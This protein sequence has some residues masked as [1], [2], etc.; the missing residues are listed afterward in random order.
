MVGVRVAAGRTDGPRRAD[1]PARTEDLAEFLLALQGIDATDGPPPESSNGFRGCDL[2]DERDSP[3]VR[4]HMAEK[5]DAARRHPRHGTDPR[6]VG[7]TL[8]P[9][10]SGH[11]SR[12]GCTA[13]RPRRTCWPA[14][15]R[16]SA[17]IDFGTLAVGDPAVDMI[18]AWS[19]LDAGQPK[20]VPRQ[21]ERRRR[22]VDTRP[23]LGADLGAPGPGQHHR[24]VGGSTDA[25]LA[26]PLVRLAQ[27]RRALQMRQPVPGEVDQVRG[28]LLLTSACARPATTARSAPPSPPATGCTGRPASSRSRA[29]LNCRPRMS[30]TCDAMSFSKR[31]ERAG[32]RRDRRGTHQDPEPVRRPLDV[33]EQRDGRPFQ[34]Q[35]GMRLLGERGG[36]LRQEVL[37]L[38][39]H[40]D[41]VH[42]FL[43]TEMLVHDR[44]GHVRPVGDLLDRTRRRNPSRRRATAPRPA[45]A[46]A[47]PHPSSARAA[48]APPRVEEAP[49]V[50]VPAA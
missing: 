32:G 26:G 37:H 29:R 23:L 2:A 11:T 16:L 33:V 12:C 42:A 44:F 39:V 10:R 50:H 25:V 4:S 8:L 30:S 22:H 43:A 20:S 38:P 49:Y 31:R 17:V 28:H 18:A 15:G 35:P 6:A 13:T 1:R 21:A 47:A 27:P 7:P 5:F 41:R 34:Q 24:G 46:A 3:V 40:D 9:P 45:A 36:H 19:L 48:W 14:D